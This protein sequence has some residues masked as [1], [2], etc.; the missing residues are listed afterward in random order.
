MCCASSP[1]PLNAEPAWHMPVFLHQLKQL[2]QCFLQRGPLFM[3]HVFLSLQA[4][5][6]LIPHCGF[7]FFTRGPHFYFCSGLPVLINPYAKPPSDMHLYTFSHMHCSRLCLPLT[8]CSHCVFSV[9]GSVFS[10][11]NILPPHTLLLYLFLK[12]T[13]VPQHCL[14]FF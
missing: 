9:T 7:F 1:F 13:S 2:T 3:T 12:M 8:D 6:A 4:H 11:F 10:S 14:T 5:A